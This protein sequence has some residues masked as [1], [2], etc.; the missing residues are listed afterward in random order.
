[1]SPMIYW[2]AVGLNTKRGIQDGRSKSWLW[3]SH[4]PLSWDWMSHLNH[5]TLWFLPQSNQFNK[6]EWPLTSQDVVRQQARCQPL[7]CFL[8]KAKV[9]ALSKQWSWVWLSSQDFHKI[10][11][12]FKLWWFLMWHNAVEILYLTA[13]NPPSLYVNLH[14]IQHLD[15]NNSL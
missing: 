8:C 3:L 2:N 14:V 15:F 6:M 5:T 11:S 7:P 4:R 1:M 10:N 13:V 12:L 9:S